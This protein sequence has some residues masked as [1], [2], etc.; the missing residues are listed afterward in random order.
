MPDRMAGIA[1]GEVDGLRASCPARAAT[2]EQPQEEGRTYQGGQNTRG[3]A[4]A[5]DDAEE[6]GT[7]VLE[8]EAF[9]RACRGT[10]RPVCQNG[11]LVGHI[12]EYTTCS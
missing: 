12:R 4:A 5:W 8:G 10:K 7:E 1:E 3:I 11:A 9:R 2:G 6:A